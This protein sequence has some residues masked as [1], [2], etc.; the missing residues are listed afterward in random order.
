MEIRAFTLVANALATGLVL[1]AIILA[2]GSVSG[3]QLNPAVAEFT[4]AVLGLAALR[5]LFPRIESRTHRD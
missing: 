4:G 2:L 1:L 3:G 5:L